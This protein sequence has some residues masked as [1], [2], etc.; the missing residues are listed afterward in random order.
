MTDTQKEPVRTQEIRV[1]RERIAEALHL[2]FGIVEQGDEVILCYRETPIRT[3]KNLTPAMLHQES[4]Y[5]HLTRLSKDASDAYREM[6]EYLFA[7]IN[8]GR[9]R[10]EP[11]TW[12]GNVFG[13]PVYESDSSSVT[14]RCVYAAT[15]LAIDDVN[16]YLEDVMQSVQFIQILHES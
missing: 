14:Q 16:A 9:T 11:R 3:I 7:E 2:V 5:P 12:D 13:H 4:S 10:S 1:A 6:V 15:Q 8:A